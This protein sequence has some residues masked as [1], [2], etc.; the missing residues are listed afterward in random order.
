MV[1]YSFREGSIKITSYISTHIILKNQPWTFDHFL[2][3]LSL[4]FFPNDKNNT[5]ST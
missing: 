3:K 2:K 1:E 5:R 4:L